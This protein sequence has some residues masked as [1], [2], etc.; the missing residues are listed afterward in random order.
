MDLKWALLV[1][2]SLVLGVASLAEDLTSNGTEIVQCNNEEL[3]KMDL[4][5]KELQ[6]NMSQLEVLIKE[7]VQNIELLDLCKANATKS[8]KANADIITELKNQVSELKLSLETQK[9]NLETQTNK[10]VT[11][12]KLVAE[13]QKEIAAKEAKIKELQTQLEEQSKKTI[14]S[15]AEESNDDKLPSSCI[16]YGNATGVLKI[17]VPGLAAFDALCDNAT[18]G[19]GWTIIQRRINGSE[20]FNRSWSEYSDGF[21]SH[22]GEFFL[23]LQKIHRLTMDQRHELYI[24]MEN[25]EGIIEFAKYDQFAVASESDHFKLL[26]LGKFSGNATEDHLSPLIYSKFSTS[27]RVN[28]ACAATR[29]GGWWFQDC[30]QT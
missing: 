29:Q 14:S 4:E 5:I 13:S 30:S 28:D 17:K 2:T 11:N 3:N 18:A 10:S 16:S 22:E 19:P 26:S 27:D 21:G 25:F 15:I 7:G 6:K 24:K 8:D 20:N 12:E 23:G 1:C 9:T